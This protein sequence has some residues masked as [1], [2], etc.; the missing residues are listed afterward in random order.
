MKFKFK[1]LL[2]LSLVLLFGLTS[3]SINLLS[4][5]KETNTPTIT[6]NPDDNDTYTVPTPSEKG[7]YTVTFV[8][9][10]GYT[11][12]STT[13]ENNKIIKPA[14]PTKICATF[15]GWY[16]DKDLKIPFDF[17]QEISSNTILY[18]GWNI[19]YISLINEA[20][21]SKMLANMRILVDNYDLSGFGVQRK[22][23]QSSSLGSGVIFFESTNGYYYLL[24][25]NHVVYTETAYQNVVVEDSYENEYTGQVVAK[26]AN[27]DLAIIRF[28]KE[29]ELKVVSLAGYTLQTD[30]LVIT[31]GEPDGL[32]NTLSFGH[33][34]G[35]KK[36]TPNEEDVKMS[37]ITFDVYMTS[38]PISSGSSGGALLDDNL[39]L[40]GINFASAYDNDT[41]EFKY[42]YSIPAYRVREFVKANLNIDI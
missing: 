22:T 33:I 38:A 42:G 17:D 40:V 5:E 1:K 20:S 32:S 9:N 27:Y 2:P 21:T 13:D 4:T 39:R 12:G 3:C 28:Q 7:K 35:T 15:K 29:K 34:I 31:M 24:T 18:A 16:T 25:N 14:N 10:N 41:K 36:F 37:N 8:C 6:L 11:Y 19:D 26:D 23:N 30:D